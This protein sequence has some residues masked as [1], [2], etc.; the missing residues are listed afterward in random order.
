MCC[1]G[2]HGVLSVRG[3]LGGGGWVSLIDNQSLDTHCMHVTHLTAVQGW[4]LL[5]ANGREGIGERRGTV[6]GQPLMI[7]IDNPRCGTQ[8][9][10]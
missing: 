10:I 6:L 3:L 7:Y 1:S 5:Q 4:T 9:Y 8:I 2:Q